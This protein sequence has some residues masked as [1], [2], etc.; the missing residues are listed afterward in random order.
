MTYSKESAMKKKSNRS[1]S[2]TAKLRLQAEKQLTIRHVPTGLIQNIADTQ[3]LVHE[4]QVH[5]V[6]LEMQ[7]AELHR[8]RLEVETALDKYTELYDFAPVGYFSIDQKGLIQEVNLMGASMLGA[9]RARLLQRRLQAFVA[10]T[11]RPVVEALLKTVFDKPGKQS[12]EALLLTTTDA[13]FWADLQAVSAVRPNGEGKWC[14]LAISDIAAL[15]RGQDAMR[16]MESLAA[17][18]L[19]AN[20][21]IARRRAAEA[22]LKESEQTQ[23]GLLIESQVLQAQLRHLT[24]QILLAQEEER[25]KIS[26]QLHDEIAQILT[27]I[28]VH[29]ATLTE[30]A[31]IRPQDLRKRISK[32]KQLVTQSID[33]VH[34]FA[35]NLRPTLLDD[36]G[37]IPALRSFVKELAEQ[38][39]L[40]INLTA[41]AG[42]ETLDISRRT[43]LYRVAQEAL[44][45][46]V[47]HAHAKSATVSISKIRDSVC[48]EIRDD[49]KSFPAE[50]LLTAKHG[51]RLGLVGMRERVEMVGGH[52]TIE[53]TPGEGTTV[54]VEIPFSHPVAHHSHKL[55]SVT[56]HTL[57]R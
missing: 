6:E 38:E 31:L 50:R 43:V 21:E 27:G 4:L 25:K 29:L 26:R 54:R 22:L 51:G 34:R 11:S 12:C 24:H 20:K 15:K 13:V 17:A 1:P 37:L 48:L 35:R 44:T 52:F 56:G 32:T 49:G 10:P 45:N 8:A 41:F 14:R 36:L 57:V 39:K 28:N 3:R 53:S 30:T 33:V 19:E 2:A 18:N 7:N 55:Q 9:V 40:R 5:Q 42:V 16:S 46:V 47:R 23:R